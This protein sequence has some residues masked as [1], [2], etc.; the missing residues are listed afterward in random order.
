VHDDALLHEL[1]VGLG[2]D[3]P[4]Q[5]RPGRALM[6]GAG[7]RVVRLPDPEPFGVLVVPLDAALSTPDVYREF[8]RTGTP[9]SAAELAALEAEL[10]AAAPPPVNDLQ[11]AA[12]ALCPAIDAALDAVRAAGAD[13]AL[14]SGSG[15]TVVGLFAEPAAAAAAAGVLALRHPRA[16]AAEPVRG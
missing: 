1:A 4:A 13:A 15:P 5:L 16:V 12:R 11:D 7:E 3:V 10:R 14:V 2:A 6:L 9:R 8:D